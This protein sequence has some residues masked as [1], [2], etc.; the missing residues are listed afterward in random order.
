MDNMFC[1]SSLENK[2]ISNFY[3]PKIFELISLFHNNNNSHFNILSTNQINKSR[4]TI[5]EDLT[6]IKTKKIKILVLGFGAIGKSCLIQRYISG[7]FYSNSIATIGLDIRAKKYGINNHDKI[8]VIRDSSGSERFLSDTK[9][10]SKSVDGYLVGFDLTYPESFKKIDYLIEQIEI[11][12]NKDCP[13]NLVIFGNICDD[14]ENI[15]VKD[16]DIEQI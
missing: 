2:N 14:L 3:S 15:K 10:L 6:K 1:L 8:L 4:K 9:I 5:N 13:L 16:E 11:Y 7:V 12:R